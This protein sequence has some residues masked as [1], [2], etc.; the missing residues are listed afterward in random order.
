MRENRSAAWRRS[1]LSLQ[2]LCAGGCL[3]AAIRNPAVARASLLPAQET[4]EAVAAPLRTILPG[5]GRAR[6]AVPTHGNTRWATKY[7]S[8]GVIQG[9]DLQYRTIPIL[10]LITFRARSSLS[11]LSYAFTD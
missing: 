7:K 6:R 1:D 9:I 2:E 3:L 10:H 8:T 4:S 5:R 11:L